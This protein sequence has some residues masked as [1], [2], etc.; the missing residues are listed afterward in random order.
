MGFK[1]QQIESQSVPH[2]ALTGL[3]NKAIAKKKK[4][5]VSHQLL[6]IEKGNPYSNAEKEKKLWSKRMFFLE[7]QNSIYLCGICANNQ[8][9]KSTR[10][11]SSHRSLSRM[12]SSA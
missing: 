3:S 12:P 11:N 8:D 2:F 1:I 7:Y 9:R 6:K 4:S 5:L 10:L